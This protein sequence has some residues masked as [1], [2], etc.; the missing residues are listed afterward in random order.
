M[1][2]DPIPLS[3]LVTACT[4]LRASAGRQI[5]GRKRDGNGGVCAYGCLQD[6]FNLDLRRLT[7][8]L[9]AF[10][11]ETKRSIVDLNDNLRLGFDEIADRLWD[12]L[13]DIAVVDVSALMQTAFGDRAPA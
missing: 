4:A 11:G 9:L 2:A 12:A 3:D 10:S 13:V 5:F 1:A 7:P 6:A 8:I